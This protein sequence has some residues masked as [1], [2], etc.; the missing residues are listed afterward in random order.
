MWG[1]NGSMLKRALIGGAA[2]GAMTGDWGGVA[3]GAAAAGAG[4]GLMSRLGPN[5]LAKGANRAASGMTR[6]GNMASRGAW[7]LTVGGAARG[8]GSRGLYGIGSGL[9]TAGHRLGQSTTMTNKWAGRAMAGM[10][11]ASAAYIGSS[12]LPSN[13]GY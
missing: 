3:G 8:W 11:V 4:W 13:R 7:D 2:G 12:V 9:R 1:L 6:L 10:G 5:Y